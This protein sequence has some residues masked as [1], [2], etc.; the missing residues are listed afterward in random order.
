MSNL[1]LSS[2]SLVICTGQTRSVMI[3]NTYPHFE[4]EKVQ[5]DPWLSTLY[6]LLPG[7][8]VPHPQP[9]HKMF[10]IFL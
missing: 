2:H 8:L 4:D 1:R 6:P 7:S 5:R 3:Q 9:P 10:S